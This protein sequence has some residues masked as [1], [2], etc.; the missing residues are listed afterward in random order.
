MSVFERHNGWFI[1]MIL[2]IN[3]VYDL[4]CI[5]N[6][7]YANHIYKTDSIKYNA[8]QYLL[9]VTFLYKNQKEICLIFFDM[10]SVLNCKGF[11]A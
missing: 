1:N 9:L 6:N 3:H 7:V 5:L 4:I 8:L 10:K 2:R 11:K